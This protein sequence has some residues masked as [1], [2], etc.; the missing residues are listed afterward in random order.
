METPLNRFHNNLER[1]SRRN[2]NEA[3]IVAN[4]PCE[5]LS[6]CQSTTG[7]ANLKENRESS[8]FYWHS[9]QDP[10]AE[11]EAWFSEFSN[12]NIEHVAVYGVGLGY[13]YQVAKDWLK[14][15]ER[16]A[17]VFFEEDP[18][19]IHRLF[20]TEL[21]SELLRNSQVSL[22][23]F[24]D[25]NYTTMGPEKYV[26]DY[27][28]QEMWFTSLVSYNTP[29]F[30]DMKARINFMMG[31]NKYTLMEYNFHG[32]V[33]LKN[34][35]YNYLDL[36]RSSLS[37]KLFGK[38]KGIPAII[39][40]AGPSLDNNIEL[41]STLRDRA[42]IFSGG[43]AMNAVNAR[44]VLPHFGVGIDPNPD[45]FTRL[46]INQAFEIPFF[47]RSRFLHEA[48]ERVH[49]DR[50][51]V[52]G[53]AG[54]GLA[55]W[56]EGQLGIA[57]EDVGEGFNV[58]NF[59]LELAYALG[60]NPIICVG[61]DLA[62]SRGS[63]YASGIIS[64]PIH[65]RR[66]NFKTKNAQEDL[67]CKNDIYGN[68]VYTLWK[69]V[70]ESMWY[71]MFSK[72]H[73]ELVM[74]NATEGGIGFPFVENL[75]LA[76]VVEKHLQKT[77]DLTTRVEGEIRSSVLPAVITKDKMREIFGSLTASLKEASQICQRIL[78]KISRQLNDADKELGDK[79][80][81][82]IEEDKKKLIDTLAYKHMLISFDDMYTK[83]HKR[84]HLRLD[85]LEEESPSIE[86][87][88]K[89]IN[90]YKNQYEYLNK[91]AL[92]Q[93]GLIGDIL[94]ESFV[95]KEVFKKWSSRVEDI[96]LKSLQTTYPLPQPASGDR[97]AYE[98]GIL[99][100]I[101]TELGI[102]FSQPFVPDIPQ[103]TSHLYHPDGKLK[104]EHY[105]LNGQLHGPSIFYDAEGNV[106]VRAWFLHG[107]QQGKMWTYYSSGS[108][109]S[110]QQFKEGRWE[111]KQYY[112]YPNGI[113]KSILSYAE[114]KLNGEVLLF[115]PYGN[116]ERKLT[117]HNGKR[118]GMEQLWD[119][120]GML[121]IEAHYVNDK[122][123][124]MAR[125]WHSNGLL[126]KEI[127]YDQQ[128]NRIQQKEWNMRGELVDPHKRHPD[129]YF[130]M[131]SHQMEKFT[132]SLA[133]MTT[134]MTKVVPFIMEAIRP[135]SSQATEEGHQK[136]QGLELE[137]S[138]QL[139]QNEIE[140]L[141]RLNQM[142]TGI[143]HPSDV[144]VE[145]PVEAIWKSPAIQQ[146]LES[147]LARMGKEMD[148]NIKTIEDGLKSILGK[149][150]QSLDDGSKEKEKGNND[151]KDNRKD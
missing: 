102:N 133:D 104:L 95:H 31:I 65:D 41:L 98:Q 38:F 79:L 94:S 96:F 88:K 97:Y 86:I 140:N 127:T 61:I 87:Q 57:G 101:D 121:C 64:H 109:H 58:L 40:G 50:L 62:Y 25:K 17:L 82:E 110:I 30:S 85:S 10:L 108:L 51:Y 114:G 118:E 20:E 55:N 99:T 13:Y 105:F 69:W 83:L 91:T 150:A 44:H 43:T 18:R 23:L 144:S 149:V 22:F 136:M 29:K 2:S 70:G 76:E 42:L 67:L 45:Q 15:N 146:E 106:L 46:V 134:Q 103:E 9:Q 7:L 148:V 124:G 26:N 47:Y 3:E 125:S 66:E 78:E 11:S 27:F 37:Q 56:I 129:D 115:H 34:F 19:V 92:F 32:A 145:N 28:I 120:F 33:V 68:P 151:N 112:L 52:T 54:H 111:G 100:I 138:L 71:T 77:H 4:T 63:S 49:G 72:N 135:P 36:P 14:A 53:T 131:V 73:P 74:I 8:E 107:K 39:C 128:S 5:A 139:L 16:R 21:G 126:A 1:W 75:S 119:E 84:E 117:F 141:A 90:L 137:P 147:K 6:F 60:C 80:A 59:S 12:K 142:I 122:P 89:R 143:S 93:A 130:D 113:P 48:L 116:L 24:S 123:V 35:Y 81:K 132:T